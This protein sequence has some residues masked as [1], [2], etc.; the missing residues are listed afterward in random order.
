MGRVI[1]LDS[2]SKTRGQVRRGLLVSFRVVR[3]YMPG[4][5]HLAK[6][7]SATRYP[8]DSS[9]QVIT[10]GPEL[11]FLRFVTRGAHFSPMRLDTPNHLEKAEKDQ[12]RNREMRNHGIK[13]LQQ[14][15]STDQLGP[16]FKISRH[17]INYV[18]LGIALLVIIDSFTCLI[19]LISYV[20][21]LFRSRS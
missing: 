10:A 4:R 12:E 16:A 21:H 13:F 17:E 15:R 19:L 14:K 5:I 11:G 8:R 20:N 7:G 9:G 2:Q 3:V 1:P 18:S 6:R